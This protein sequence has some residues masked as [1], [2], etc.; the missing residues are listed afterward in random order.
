MCDSGESRTG[1]TTHQTFPIKNKKN[2]GILLKKKLEKTIPWEL[3]TEI[4]DK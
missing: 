1:V 4:Y 2:K 3:F